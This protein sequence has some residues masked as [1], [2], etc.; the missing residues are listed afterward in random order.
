MQKLYKKYEIL[1]KKQ[2]AF[3]L[4]AEEESDIKRVKTEWVIAKEKMIE[5]HLNMT[6]FPYL[7]NE[8]SHKAVSDIQE[9]VPWNGGIILS[10]KELQDISDA[11]ANLSVEQR[12]FIKSKL[13]YIHRLILQQFEE[14]CSTDEGWEYMNDVSKVLTNKDDGDIIEVVSYLDSIYR[15]FG[16]LLGITLDEVEIYFDGGENDETSD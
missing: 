9:I 3:G 12:E 5:E 4:T 10:N 1:N 16:E 7:L 8:Y 6:L 15:D 13:E 2:Q 11:E 14:F